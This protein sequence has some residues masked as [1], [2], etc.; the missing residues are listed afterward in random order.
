MVQLENRIKVGSGIRQKY[1]VKDDWATTYIID[2]AFGYFV[3]RN[4]NILPDWFL[5]AI[6]KGRW[7]GRDC[8]MFST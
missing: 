6:D 4:R 7:V 8:W 5:Q 3:S 1:S 2:G